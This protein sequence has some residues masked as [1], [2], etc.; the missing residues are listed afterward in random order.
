MLVNSEELDKLAREF[1]TCR[2]ILLALGDESRQHL[3]L[4]MMQ[5]EDCG[6]VRVGEITERT[7]LSRPA[8]SH[9]I[10]ILKEAG[11]LKVRREGTK[12][13]YY[14]DVDMD[15]LSQLT[16]MLDHIKAVMRSLPDRSGNENTG[17]K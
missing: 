2:Q 3:I 15:A 1:E 17:G 11:I 6:G 14:F 10:R 13:Y 8:V 9:H 7:H 4:E 5:M 12:N 16:Q